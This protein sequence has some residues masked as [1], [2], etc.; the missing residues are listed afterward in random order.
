MELGTDPAA[1]HRWEALLD[2][3]LADD[4]AVD[5]IV[6]TIRAALPIYRT[7]PDDEL[8]PS[9]QTAVQRVLLAA[10]VHREVVGD[11]EHLAELT[12]L[13]RARVAQGIPADQML[14]AWRIGFQ[15]VFT[16]SRAVARRLSIEPAEMLEFLQS[17]IAWSDRAMVVV[18]GA[19]HRAALDV[20]REEQESRGG[21]VRALLLG[22]LAP[23]QIRSQ[24]AAYGIDP[25]RTFVAIRARLEDGDGAAGLRARLGLNES[26]VPAMGLSAMIDGDFVALL[27]DA[28]ASLEL[29]GP[30]GAGPPRPLAALPES[31]AAATRALHTA[32]AFGLTGI[33]AFDALGLA[34]AI[35]SD[36][37]VGAVLRRRYIEPLDSAAGE[38]AA[39]LRTW[40]DC[41]MHVE[42]AATLLFVHQNTLRYRMGRFEE[43]TGADLK[44]TAVAFEVWWALQV[45][46][47]RP[48]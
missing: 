34:P 15:V 28:P 46:S 33:H 19:H 32:V 8:R 2:G 41:G 44:D 30:V 26:V 4:S 25:A 47:L 14:L 9:L 11:D 37:E 36:A 29:A 23:E 16:H 39:S 48:T 38:L 7:I 20:A 40:F 45:D 24:A 13:G 12:E 22:T 35:A 3:V 27:P 10:R 5:D 43:L 31:F 1:Q 6:A 21:F 18:A 42:R 17:L